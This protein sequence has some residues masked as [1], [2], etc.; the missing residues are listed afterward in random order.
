M[1]IRDRFG[2]LRA[3]GHAVSVELDIAD[4]VTEKAVD[5]FQPDVLLAPFLKR[6]IP[7]SIWRRVVCLVVHPGVPGD[8]GPSALDWA[9]MRGD[10][11]GGDTVSRRARHTRA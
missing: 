10:T 11:L 4:S 5:M 2:V 9:L 8:R 3:Q 6:R 7:E 1:C